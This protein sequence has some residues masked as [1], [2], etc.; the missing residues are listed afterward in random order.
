[1]TLIQKIM[2]FLV[3]VIIIPLMVALATIS[4]NS[5]I[6]SDDITSGIDQLETQFA[7]S[8]GMAA[9]DLNK[10][11]ST[12]M[13]ALTQY[14]WER[15]A[16]NLADQVASFLYERDDDLTFLAKTIAAHDGEIKPLLDRF[17]QQKTK[18]VTVHADYEYDEAS[19]QWVKM[20]Q[21][22][23]DGRYITTAINAENERGFRYSS[24]QRREQIALPVYREIA[25]LDQNGR[26]IIKS[27]ELGDELRDITKRQNTF[28][29]SERYFLVLKTLDAG[30]I[31]VS[32]VI[33]AYQ[34]ADM[35][36]PYRKDRAKKAGQEFTPAQSGYAG[37]E[38]P[39]GK[40]FEGII[41]YA[42]PIMKNGEVSGYL[43][44]AV[45]HRHVMEF[46]DFIV[47]E[48]IATMG[49]GIE[50]TRRSFY[51]DIKD[52]SKGNYAFM[53]D[54]HGRSIAHPREYFISGFDPETGKRV[55][56]WISADRAKAFAASGE[57]DLNRWI[58]KQRHYVNQSREKKPNV[59]QIKEG[60]VPLDCRYL[61]FAPQ[62]HGWDQIN[63]NGGYGSFQIFWSGIWKLTT[64]ATIPYYTG[65]YGDGRRGFGFVTI[66]ANIG[67]YTKSGASARDALNDALGEVNQ[68]VSTELRDLGQNARNDLM[69]FQNQL[70]LIAAAM[71]F[72]VA[73]FSILGSYNFRT[74]IAVL[75]DRTAEL[76]R[77]NMNARVEISGS[78]ELKRIG[79][80]FNVMATTIQSSQDE[81]GVINTN[82]E[83]MVTQ[84]TEEL[85]ESNQQI[86]DSIDYASRIQRSLLPDDET[87]RRCLGD[88]NIIW[89]PKDVVGGDFYW[90]KTIGDRDFLVVM[91]CTGHGVPG[92]FMTLIATST[93]EQITAATVASLGRWAYTPDPAEILQSL[94]EGVCE[95]LHQVGSGSLSN[96][97]LDAIIISIPHDQT[98]LEICGAHIDLFTV[99]PE[100][101]VTRYRGS[102]TSLGY[103]NDGEALPLTTYEIPLD[104]KL[105]FVVTT[106]G[107]PTQVGQDV[108]RSYGNKRMIS[109][110]EEAA[111][112]S[113]KSLVRSL[114]RD[115]RTWQ[116]S[117][118]RRDD[119]TLF[120]F[121]PKIGD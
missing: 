39:V 87:L 17:R 42:T 103:Q 33:G 3:L 116:G 81:L 78:D 102:K 7:Q 51:T 48:N 5:R 73:G 75:L 64:V 53:W 13:D 40:R 61:D 14:N 23:N 41:R 82:L 69:S 16:V 121:K 84:R 110:M 77:G 79:D 31:F 117:G 19:H 54:K 8:I 113:P 36:G 24:R 90:H 11:S 12:E 120:A 43:T 86:S 2:I 114:M 56:P 98:A 15:L 66:G 50:N 101:D 59:A 30:E 29:A 118:E 92:A 74:R 63:R 37:T 62:C 20:S 18:M 1:M 58:S 91:D 4:I 44:M 115:F 60:R 38:N 26:E 97:G 107:I 27:S 105:S 93:L 25:V 96:D 32:E 111:D 22:D 49:E 89:Q 9:E 47:P 34:G 68:T 21:D 108:R 80:A 46:T 67:E 52:A 72:V 71:M 10:S 106:D 83:K 45:N 70:F 94:H 65:A 104:Q 95:Q 55:A 35:I 109:K 100:M 112:N 6:I 99:S 85:R 88:Y 57:D 28:A 119:I 76:A